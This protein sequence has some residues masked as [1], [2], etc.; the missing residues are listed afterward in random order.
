MAP[1]TPVRRNYSENLSASIKCH[2]LHSFKEG[3]IL[4][5]QS[6]LKTSEYCIYMAQ[7]SLESLSRNLCNF[8]TFAIMLLFAD[9]L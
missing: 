6:I 7:L 5:C 4:L 3:M 9:M 8:S 2:N 1:R